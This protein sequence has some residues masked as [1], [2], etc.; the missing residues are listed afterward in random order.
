MGVD[1]SQRQEIPWVKA[2]LKPAYSHQPRGTNLI[3]FFDKRRCSEADCRP[4][5]NSVLQSEI[6]D[7]FHF[8]QAPKCQRQRAYQKTSQ[9]GPRPPGTRTHHR[10]TVIIGVM[11]KVWIILPECTQTCTNTH[12]SHDLLQDKDQVLD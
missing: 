2:R 8:V 11:F 6:K 12:T 5:I 7:L 9:V 1:P 3:H 10:G 4:I